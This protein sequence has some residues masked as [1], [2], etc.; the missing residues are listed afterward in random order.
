VLGQEGLDLVDGPGECAGV[1]VEELGEQVSGAE[2]AQ[3][4]HGGEDS[5]GGGQVVLGSCTASADA[6]ASPLLEPIPLS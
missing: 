3:L 1:D 4:E 5:V 6:F 2:F